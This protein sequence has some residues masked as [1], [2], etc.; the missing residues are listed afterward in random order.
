MVTGLLVG[1]VEQWAES[2]SR[3]QQRQRGLHVD[4]DVAGAE[5]GW[6]GVD[7]QLGAE[8]VVDQQRPDV[9]EA[10][11]ADQVVD[12][13]AAVPQRPAVPV[14]FGDGGM[15]R[16]HTLQ[17]GDEAGTFAVCRGRVPLVVIDVTSTLRVANCGGGADGLAGLRLRD[18][19]R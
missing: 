13:D 14:G 15:E 11:L 18:H 16:D 6:G 12:V 17:P 3:G 2:A 19:V 7:R 5:G 1:D 9:L 4:P 10:D 8:L